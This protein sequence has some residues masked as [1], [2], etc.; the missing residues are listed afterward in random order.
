MRILSSHLDFSCQ[1]HAFL[2]QSEM[3]E[4][5]AS[6]FSSSLRPSSTT[7]GPAIFDRV[8][9][10]STA[11]KVQASSQSAMLSGSC[12]VLSRQGDAAL[13]QL[14]KTSDTWTRNSAT[15]GTTANSASLFSSNGM[16]PQGWSIEFNATK[17]HYESEQMSTLI[18]GTVTSADGRTISFDLNLQF[19]RQYASVEQYGFQSEVTLSDPL[20]INFRGG[21]PGLSEATFAFDLNSDAEQEMI[22][23][24]ASGSGFLALDRNG[25]KRINNGTE[26]FGPS[27][28]KGY[29]ELARYDRDSN[30]WIDENDGIF[31]ELL[32]WTRDDTGIDKLLTLKDAGIGAISLCSVNSPFSL[33]DDENRVKGQVRQTGL[34][35]FEDGKAGIMQQIDLAVKEVANAG[36]GREGSSEGTSDQDL[37]DETTRALTSIGRLAATASWLADE[38]RS[39]RRS[40]QEFMEFKRKMQDGSIKQQMKQPLDFIEW[41][42]RQL[43]QVAHRNRSEES[44]KTGHM[45]T[46]V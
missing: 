33:T 42:D 37:P 20:V 38:C 9:L 27:T 16:I 29:S 21:I 28:G 39:L 30:G 46:F 5:Q 14:I 15:T 13:I 19:N 34:C 36:N 45:V 3:Q 41:I 32:I 44:K 23:A 22:Y 1:S 10:S 2:A 40:F 35:L 4:L 18:G 17:T 6:S 26:L 25:D 7:S 8:T 12:A 11:Q 31:Q 43:Q 24:T